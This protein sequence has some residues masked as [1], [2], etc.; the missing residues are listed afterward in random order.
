MN[1][2]IS[3]GNV[4][5]SV[6]L[7]PQA[8]QNNLHSVRFRLIHNREIYNFTPGFN[9]TE[10]DFIKI[11]NPFLKNRELIKTKDQIEAAFK[12]IETTIDAI[13]ENGEYS[14]DKLRILLKVGKYTD[15]LQ[16]MDSMILNYESEGRV[17]NAAIY[18]NAKA[19]LKRYLGEKVPFKTV[20][21]KVLETLTDKA[22]SNGM[23]QTTLSIYLRTIRA[24]YNRAIDANI[25]ERSLYPFTQNEGHDGKYQIKEGEGTHIALSVFQMSQIAKMEF[26]KNTPALRRSRD[27]FILIFHMGG[28][29]IGD[30]LCLKWKDIKNGE[31]EF[32]RKKTTRTN[33]KEVIIRVPV[34]NS[35]K[36]YF[37][38]YG[39]PEMNPDDYILPFMQ[40]AKNNADI[41]KITK[42]FTRIINKHLAK[43]SKDLKLPQISTY[44][45]RHSFAT[46]TKNSGASE[47]FIKEALGHSSLATTQRYLKGFEGKQREEIFKANERLINGGD[48]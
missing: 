25:I 26:S 34:T 12:R 13:I 10:S 41:K 35:I 5:V 43:I 40:G 30:L 9:L 48:Q 16:F 29:N 19:F 11:S 45:A 23:R 32:K 7:D 28:I 31:I 6:F 21:P 39:T 2:R 22:K 46:I 24:V 1:K 38:L 4:S 37:D 15:V 44:V 20:T 47:S 8:K 27:L 18:S 33:S 17:G 36:K 14:H 3:K 42:N